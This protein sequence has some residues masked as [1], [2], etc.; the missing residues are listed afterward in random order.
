MDRD[1][2]SCLRLQYIIQVFIILF[3]MEKKATYKGWRTFDTAKVIR[4]SCFIKQP[5]IISK[6]KANLFTKYKRLIYQDLLNYLYTRY[7]T[8][9]RC[10]IRLYILYIFLIS[11]NKQIKSIISISLLVPIS[12]YLS[13]C[14]FVAVSAC[15]SVCSSVCLF[16]VLPDCLSSPLSVSLSLYPSV[17]LSISRFIGLSVCLSIYLSVCV[18]LYLSVDQSV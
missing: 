4:K 10:C 13:L 2:N 16:V 9:R 15:M 14:L 7:V 6:L 18:H 17:C 3:N 1:S 11:V 5:L 12:V 8:D